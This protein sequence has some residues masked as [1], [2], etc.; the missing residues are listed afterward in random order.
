M[1]TQH[2]RQATWHR[3]VALSVAL[4]IAFMLWLEAKC[5]DVNAISRNPAKYASEALAVTQHLTVV[6]NRDEGEEESPMV[7]DNDNIDAAIRFNRLDDIVLVIKTGATESLQ[8]LPAHFNTTLKSW[9]HGLLL[10][11]FSEEIDGYEV[12]DALDI[13]SED[14]RAQEPSF[15]M[16]NRLRKGGRSAL[17][18]TDPETQEQLQWAVKGW[19]QRRDGWRRA[20]F[21][22][23]PMAVKA[24]EYKPDARWYV[25]IDADTYISPS[26]L[27]R[28][29][30]GL[31][32]S[33]P[34]YAGYQTPMGPGLF[35]A[36]GGSGYLLS[37]AALTSVV[38]RYRAERVYY[39]RYAQEHE[40]GEQPLSQ[41]LLDL[42]VHLTW[43]YPHFQKGDPTAM[44]WAASD[45]GRKLWCYPAITYHHVNAVAI[46]GLWEFEEAWNRG[47]DASRPLHHRDVFLGVV[48][49]HI[50]QSDGCDWDNL[51]D[52]AVND[53]MSE[54]ACRES[55]QRD[56]AC[57]QYSYHDGQCRTD[58]SPKL[59]LRK[60][61]ASS[62]WKV[63]RI[64][65]FVEDLDR[66]CDEMML[67]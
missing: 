60:A 50:S 47:R 31:D 4:T 25:F 42:D 59:G 11:D 37:Q 54:E 52:N 40:F 21:M 19:S 53:A 41:A 15:E 66:Q 12:H 20:R 27:L 63:D 44:D 1:G 48:L 65:R 18:D 8:K 10:S 16:W 2:Q 43:S 17:F 35:F 39:D 14:V 34:I 26:N 6:G 38:E 5:G 36:H 28:M 56:E 22:N 57:I 55:C 46:Q 51:S 45:H 30:R 32:S 64:Q 7:G 24:Q 62:G 9:P 49:P 3:C 58:A 33:T 61:G 13:V 23:L 67:V 29:V